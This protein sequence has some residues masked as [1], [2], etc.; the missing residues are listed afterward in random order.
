MDF[1]LQNLIASLFTDYK[2]DNYPYIHALIKG[3]L[4]FLI[5]FI[6]LLTKDLLRGIHP[7]I[8]KIQ[9]GLFIAAVAW[10]IST[11]MFLFGAYIKR[12]P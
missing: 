11:L 6:G 1:F 10:F 3:A 7:T 4:M 9:V 12:N 8:E 2:S 5:V